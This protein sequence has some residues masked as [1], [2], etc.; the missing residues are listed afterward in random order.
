YGL[1]EGPPAG[2]GHEVLVQKL[3]IE[4]VGV[5]EVDLLA[6]FERD[7]FHATVVRIEGNDRGAGQLAGQLPRQFRLA[8]AGRP[9]NTDDV[10][11]HAVCGGV[12]LVYNPRSA[13]TRPSTV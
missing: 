11:S 1:V 5:I 7:L 13:S 10:C 4:G 9:G 2:N 6:F 12:D 8:G 3:P